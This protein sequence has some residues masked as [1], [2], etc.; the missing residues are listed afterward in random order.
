MRN[1]LL[2]AA[3][4]LLLALAFV[5]GR[6]TAHSN[7]I[8]GPIIQSDTIY[9]TDTIYR[10]KPPVLRYYKTT[11][12]MRIAVRDTIRQ[13]DTLIVEI[14]REVKEYRDSL[15]S[16]AVSGIEP[17]LD[18]IELYP[19]R[20]VIT[21]TRLQQVKARP[22]LSLG[23]QAGYGATFGIQPQLRP[24]IGIGV[25]YNLVSFGYK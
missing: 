20:E 5:T 18:W 13:H 22:R 3:L 10:E 12:T 4:L 16:L 6:V 24:Y 1:A 9:H 21:Q 11:D 23:V 19:V 7:P 15:F 25:Q 14:P 17:E 2:A 8:D